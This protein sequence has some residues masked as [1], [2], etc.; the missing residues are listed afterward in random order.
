MAKRFTVNVTL[1]EDIYKK[2]EVESKKQV[3]SMSNIAL[4]Y[5][6]QGLEGNEVTKNKD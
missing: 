4:F 1:P 2:L 3:R 6:L 5:I